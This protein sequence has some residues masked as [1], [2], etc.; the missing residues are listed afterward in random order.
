MN[1][2]EAIAYL[3]II[4]EEVL[5][6]NEKG[7]E[8]IIELL[9]QQEKQIV[10]LENEVETLHGELREVYAEDIELKKY[11]GMWEEFSHKHEGECWNVSDSMAETKD[12]YFP[13]EEK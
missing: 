9:Q 12:K 10:D 3:K 4:A 1:T 2:K 11:K 7:C 5:L 8:E 13:E 6:E